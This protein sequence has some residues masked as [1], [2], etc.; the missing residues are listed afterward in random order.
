MRRGFFWGRERAPLA[1]LL[2]CI[3][4]TQTA[5]LIALPFLEHHVAVRTELVVVR[6]AGSAD[7]QKAHAVLL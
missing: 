6:N 5:N 2:A 1:C 4:V 7:V 3:V